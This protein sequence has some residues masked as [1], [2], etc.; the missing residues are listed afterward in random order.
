ME[1]KHKLGSRIVLWFSIL[2][3][4][5]VFVTNIFVGLEYRNNLLQSYSSLAYSYTRAAAQYIDGDRVP[6]YLLTGEKD[7]YYDLVSD[8]LKSLLDQSKLLYYYVFV[9]CSDDLVYI[10]D[11]DTDLGYHENY[12][13]GGKESVARLLEPEYIEEI[14]ITP[15]S[16]YGS[17]ASA[18]S[19]IYDS[20]GNCVA[21]VGADL[22]MG[23][24]NKQIINFIM[25]LG[26]IIWAI[27]IL[28]TLLLYLLIRRYVV[29][30]INSLSK[31]TEG[32]VE[33]I[34]NN[35]EFDFDIHTGDEIENLAF[36]F[37]SMD[38]EMKEYI[39]RLSEVTAERERI[40]AEL[41]VA[42]QIQASM[43][44]SIFPAFPE[45]SEFDIFASMNPAKEVGGDF[46]DFFMVDETHL[47][48]VIA[49]V[50]GKGVPA[51]LFMVIAKTLLKDHTDSRSDLGDVFTTVNRMLCEANSEEMFVTAFEGVLDLESGEFRY[52]NAGHEI[53]FICRKGGI[54]E[55]YPI[56]A[57][58]VLA[59]MEGLRYKSG[60]IQMNPGD[61]LFQYT[62]GVTEA[63]DSNNQLYGME[64]LHSILGINSACSPGE[65]LPLI[66]QDLDAFAGD[67]PQFDDITMLCLEYKNKYEKKQKQE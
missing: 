38:H 14:K 32:I 54:Y 23:N 7:E 56:K 63:T 10:W 58:F 59:G 45:Q 27:I 11:E 6:Q 55:T 24:I 30:P 66:K 29:L 16:E 17:I 25:H 2:A 20:D 53:P 31:A 12:M 67:A 28:S 18:F 65:L 52:V 19:P 1:K 33:R 51:A 35:E 15:N 48:I 22:S 34:E 43:L 57:G 39:A 60:V 50:S 61:K 5:L 9:P 47:A 44:P 46:Y 8:Y 42:K 49:D 26:I 21:I 4:Q 3:I 37:K 40:G 36:S 13:P 41:N 64:R 62:D